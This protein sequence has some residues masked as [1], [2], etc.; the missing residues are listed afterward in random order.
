MKTLEKMTSFF[1][2]TWVDTVRQ[3]LSAMHTGY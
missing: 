3:T 2:Y 1:H